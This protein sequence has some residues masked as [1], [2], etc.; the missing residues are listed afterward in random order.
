MTIDTFPELLPAAMSQHIAREASLPQAPGPPQGR[1]SGHV[2]TSDND[3][4]RIPR[5]Q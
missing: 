2:R 1:P 3:L 5:T 4:R